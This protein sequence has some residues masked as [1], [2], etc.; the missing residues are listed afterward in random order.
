MSMRNYAVVIAA[1]CSAIAYLIC[2][3]VCATSGLFALAALCLLI[4]TCCA[5]LARAEYLK[6]RAEAK[7]LRRPPFTTTDHNNAG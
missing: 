1:T 2:L 3:F 6:V 7:A 4:S 5:V